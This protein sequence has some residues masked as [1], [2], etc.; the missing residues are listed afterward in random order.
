[1]QPNYCAQMMKSPT[2]LNLEDYKNLLA[3]RA[4]E[5]HKGIFGH[6]LIVG[7]DYG[8]PGAMRLAAEA[9]LRCGLS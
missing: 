6:V 5:A 9:A 1:M 4:R 7:G 2:L 3:P 8:M